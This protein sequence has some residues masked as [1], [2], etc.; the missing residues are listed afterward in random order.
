MGD[1]PVSKQHS[2]DR[3]CFKL[4][5]NVYKCK[6]LNFYTM[7]KFIKLDTLLNKK[8]VL[9]SPG[10]AEPKI[11]VKELQQE[12]E[13]RH[14][15][16]DKKRGRQLIVCQEYKFTHPWLLTLNVSLLKV[17][18]LRLGGHKE[19]IL[20]TSMTNLINIQI[21]ERKPL[22]YDHA[23]CRGN[24]KRYCRGLVKIIRL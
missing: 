20:S 19:A 16:Q 9:R 23:L 18:F 17:R 13:R 11:V 1:M 15:L 14:Q 2:V 22:Y 8:S 21:E 7:V 24:T 6:K 12:I 5:G 4:Y 10:C 3:P